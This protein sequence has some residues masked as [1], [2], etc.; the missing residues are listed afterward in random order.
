MELVNIH[1]EVIGEMYKIASINLSPNT[2]GQVS[3]QSFSAPSPTCLRFVSGSAHKISPAMHLTILSGLQGA[4]I[5]RLDMLSGFCHAG[6]PSKWPERSSVA[7]T[8][9]QCS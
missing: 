9:G 2:M 7:T 4:H 8:S 6:S 5:L 1:P 3:L